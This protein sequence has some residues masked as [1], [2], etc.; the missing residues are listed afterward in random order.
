M[1]ALCSGESELVS[2]GTG[3]GVCGRA[4]VGA[5]VAVMD[6]VVAETRLV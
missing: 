3:D 2:D 1:Q 5:N 6:E 4:R